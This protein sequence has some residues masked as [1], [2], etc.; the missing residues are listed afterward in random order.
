MAY[1]VIEYNEAGKPKCEICGKYYDRVLT[2]V[3]QKHQLGEKQY[4]KQFGFDLTKGICSASSA[5]IIRTKTLENFDKCIK[6]NLLVK[7]QK[8]RYIV[9]SKGRTRDK[10]SEQTKRR[11]ENNFKINK[12]SLF[13]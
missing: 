5:E 6:D 11:L 3:R 13:I 9:G 8:T 10:L 7:G 1:G 2:H 4:K 12:N